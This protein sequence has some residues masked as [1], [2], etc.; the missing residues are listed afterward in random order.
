M[1]DSKYYDTTA[2][3]QVIGCVLNN[4]HLL[5]EDGSYTFSELDFVNE[6]HKVIFG[7]LY[8]LYNMGTTNLNTKTVEDYLQHKPESLA[9]YTAYKGAEWLHKAF[10]VAEIENFDYYYSRL[11]KMTLLRA[12][13]N[14]GLNLSWLYDIDNVFDQELREKQDKQFDTLSLNELAELIENRISRVREMVVDNDSDESCQIGDEAEQLLQELETT[15]AIGYPLYDKFY[16]RIAMGA[17][18][19]KIKNFFK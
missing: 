4:P 17:R 11:R 10:Q 8:N 7:S 12:Y 16:D 5:D 18:L 13:D 14:I 2:A 1:G 19:G 3:I 6:F 15:P 9:I